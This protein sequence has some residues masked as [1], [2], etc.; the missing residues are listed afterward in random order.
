[1]FVAS[2]SPSFRATCKWVCLPLFPPQLALSP[3]HTTFM[4]VAP[5]WFCRWLFGFHLCRV[6]VSPFCRVFCLARKLCRLY[7]GSC[8]MWLPLRTCVGV[9]VCA[10]VRVQVF[11]LPT[12]RWVSSGATVWGLRVWLQLGRVPPK[13]MTTIVSIWL[14]VCLGLLPLSVWLIKITL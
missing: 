11:V 2:K 12:S 14:S 7:R 13:F 6:S 5:F 9:S 3:P 4:H 8:F 10:G 1:M